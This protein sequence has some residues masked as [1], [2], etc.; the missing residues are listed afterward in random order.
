VSSI[1][2]SCA[3]VLQLR[4]D[5]AF[6]Q[7]D[8]HAAAQLYSEAIQANPNDGKLWSNRSACAAQLQQYEQALA[9]ATH[10]AALLPKW[11]K[12]WSRKGA[13]S[14]PT[15]CRRVHASSAVRHPRH[16]NVFD[17]FPMSS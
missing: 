8:Y 15:C 5:L 1:A 11:D 10:A 3:A 7:R 4:A 6:Q 14:L 13:F 2:G 16:E 17:W 12:G 9:D